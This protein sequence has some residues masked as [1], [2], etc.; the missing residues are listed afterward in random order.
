[1]DGRWAWGFPTVV[2]RT[3]ALAR[4]V[5]LVSSVRVAIMPVLPHAPAALCRANLLP[6]CAGAVGVACDVCVC[7]VRLRAIKCHGSTIV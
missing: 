2:W 1:M 3:C 5:E 4:R 7:G 6:T